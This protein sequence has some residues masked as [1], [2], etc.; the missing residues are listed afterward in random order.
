MA[1]TANGG[2][3]AAAHLAAPAA[4]GDAMDSTQH[5]SASSGDAAA[6]QL[7]Q[8]FLQVGRTSV[9]AGAVF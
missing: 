1:A 4:N 3:M 8:E 6:L 7:L 9:R 2:A 5:S